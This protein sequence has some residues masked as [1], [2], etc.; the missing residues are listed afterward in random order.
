MLKGQE[1]GVEDKLKEL[2]KCA[3]LYRDRLGLTFKKTAG[4]W[5]SFC[6]LIHVNERKEK[7][8]CRDFINEK[9]HFIV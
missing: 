2:N 3:T 6:L 7:K 8:K 9:P 1:R 4:R 5:I